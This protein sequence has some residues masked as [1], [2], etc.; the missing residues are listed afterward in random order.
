MI[1]EEK[2]PHEIIEIVEKTT[3]EGEEQIEI[4]QTVTE[5]SGKKIVKRTKKKKE[6][7]PDEI[8]F[9]ILPEIISKEKVSFGTLEIVPEITPEGKEEVEII[10]TNEEAG[11]K[12]SK[13]VKRKKKFLKRSLSKPFLK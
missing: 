2:V 12:V 9:E 3:A 7:L 10:Q 8:T 1:I 11:K 5:E 13:K 4:T 6:T